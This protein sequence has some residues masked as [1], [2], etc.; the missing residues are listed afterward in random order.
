MKKKVLSFIC[1]IFIIFLIFYYIFSGNGN[2]NFKKSNKEIIENILSD[3][4]SYTAESKIIIYSNKNQNEYIVKQEENENHSY[5]EITSKGNL[6]GLIIEY[7][8]NKLMVKNTKLNLEKIY[9]ECKEITN[10]YLFLKTFIKEYKE[11]DNVGEYEEDDNNIIVEI[12]L[13]NPT[14]YI[15]YKKLYIDKS[16]GNPSKLII[17]NSAKQDVSCIEYINVVT[18]K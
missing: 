12:E 14:K 9:E 8:D 18:Q 16:S 5:Q 7:A 17:K 15:K 13:K 4:F 3:K 6:Q 11:S 10:S 1:I 2:N